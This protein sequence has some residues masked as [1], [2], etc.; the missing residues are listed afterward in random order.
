[1]EENQKLP[2]LLRKEIIYKKVLFNINLSNRELSNMIDRSVPIV[3]KI[4]KEL[5]ANNGRIPNFQ[6]KNTGSRPALKYSD[7]LIKKLIA[8]YQKDLL[9]AG[10]GNSSS[11][12]YL[13]LHL[14]WEK[15][16]KEYGLKISESQLYKR[17]L[18]F[19]VISP[20]GR[21]AGRKKAKEALKKLKLKNKT[22]EL[23]FKFD[24]PF[25]VKKPK[26]KEVLR[27]ER[28]RNFSF[29]D[30]VEIDACYH[31]FVEKKN[32]TLVAGID[33]GTGL[34]LSM[35]F[36]NKAESLQAHQ[37]NIEQ[38]I[39]KHGIPKSIVTDNRM[40][41]YNDGETG[42]STYQAAKNLGIDFITSSNSNDKPHIERLFDFI[43]KRLAFW[44]KENGIT[45]IEQANEHIAEI[46][47]YL[48]NVRK[49]VIK[50]P[51][52]SHFRAPNIEKNEHLFDLEIKNRKINNGVIRYDNQYLAPYD[53][54]KRITNFEKH[55][56]KFVRGTDGKLYFRIGD[57]RYEAKPLQMTDLELFEKYAIEK[58]LPLEVWEVNVISRIWSQG[59]SFHK[60]LDTKIQKLMTKSEKL[61]DEEIKLL[62][63]ILEEIKKVHSEIGKFVDI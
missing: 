8:E 54:E 57:K 56:T 40:N 25:L 31:Y 32:W 52:V 59:F 11:D 50:N 22:N 23:T 42:A 15:I 39:S 21:K 49:S 29:G 27:T 45:T 18:M 26:K 20:Y 5:I 12:S 38:I 34:I 33:V 9:I 19:G 58:R 16:R 48:N 35:Y 63:D 61:T 62:K 13:T 1:M 10:T 60:V 44:F 3:I 47:D 28:K 46:I 55:N 6:H 14:F 37:I 43:Q 51:K 30:R 53:R 7:E 4:K 2:Y 24:K 17:F 41:F 36:E